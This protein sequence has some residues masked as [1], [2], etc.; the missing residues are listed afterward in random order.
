MAKVQNVAPRPVHIG[1][2]CLKSWSGREDSNLR[3]L[4]P[5]GVSPVRIRRFSV[6][7]HAQAGAPSASCCHAVHGARF[8]MNLGHCLSA[9]CEVG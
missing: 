8:N 6:V 2:K 9:A 7:S 1:A 3:P 5:E 4:P